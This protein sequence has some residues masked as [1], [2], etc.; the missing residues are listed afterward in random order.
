[1]KRP[2]LAALAFLALVNLT[3]LDGCRAYEFEVVQPPGSKSLDEALVVI[4]DTHTGRK[5]IVPYPTFVELSL[6][7]YKSIEALEK[8]LG[9]P[10]QKP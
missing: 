6:D 4:M 3:G 10:P 2:L 5:V 7:R 9:P 8:A 1:M